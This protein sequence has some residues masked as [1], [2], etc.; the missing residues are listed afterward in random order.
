MVTK[1]KIRAMRNAS[2]FIPFI[3]HTTRGEVVRVQRPGLILAASS[4][5][6]VIVKEPKGQL[7]F[8]D[9]E[10]IASVEEAPSKAA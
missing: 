7:H 8:I 10:F 6:H 3:I 2:P 1:E 4:A 9:L 5:P